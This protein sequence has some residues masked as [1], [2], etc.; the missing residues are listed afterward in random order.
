MI[1]LWTT[2]VGRYA[3]SNYGLL[4]V[5]FEV[6][7]KLFA[8]NQSQKKLLFVLRD[9]NQHEHNKEKMIELLE[10]NVNKIWGEIYKSEKFE[11]SSPHDF[12][13]FEFHMMP[14]KMYQPNEF[15]EAGLDLKNK[16]DVNNPD[17]LF[18]K[19]ET[20][21]VPI[22][23][24]P[25]YIEN[26]WTCIREQKELNLP[27]E[28]QMVATYRCG[29]I[30]REAIEVVQPRLDDFQ[31][32][33]NE[34]TI[35]DYKDQCKDILKQAYAHYDEY[36]KQ[37]YQDTYKSVKVELTDHIVDLL[38]KSYVSQLKYMRLQGDKKFAKALKNSFSDSVVPDSFHQTCQDLYR[39]TVSQFK[40]NA[41]ALMMEGSGWENAISLHGKDLENDLQKQIELSREKQKDKLFTF[42]FENIVD[43]IEEEIT[44]PI[45]DL[46]D[47]MWSTITKRYTEIVRTEEEKV[48]DVLVEGFKADDDETDSFMTRLEEKVYDQANK[49]IRRCVADLNSHL[50][51]KFNTYFKKDDK[52]KNRDWKSIPEEEIEKLHNECYHQ[53]DS[54]FDMFRKMEIPQYVT[55]NTPTMGGSFH[56]KKD[57]LLSADEITRI[58]DKF[59]QDCEHALEE[60]IRLHH[61][62]YNNGIPIYFWAIFIFFAYDD[63]LRWLSSPVL[64]YPMLFL[65]TVAALM[66]SLGL[67]MPA[68][69]A[70]RVT[71][72]IA[73]NQ[74]QSTRRK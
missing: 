20:Q 9:F 60:A 70:A 69:Q 52:G 27:G 34:G 7:L 44:Q 57:Q 48:R 42:S 28:K 13:E 30:K 43:E 5:I 35:P 65:A 38:Y 14:H 32:Q 55:M 36:A 21:N 62:I 66:Q 54:Y 56:S 64:F 73:Y 72:S 41:K 2:D 19:V 37:Y 46:E 45:K 1:N 47:N 22:D 18:P 6:N 26:C 68:V 59:E 33:S 16:F 67:L 39:D 63:I 8:Q 50:N 3:A 24:L 4:K 10:G 11:K 12:F 29:E 74:F 51:R 15:K 53:F 49:F 40:T 71:I 25:M 17:T 23:G 61:N 31:N 58:R